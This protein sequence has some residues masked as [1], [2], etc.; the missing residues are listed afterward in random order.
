MASFRSEPAPARRRPG[1]VLMS[2]SRECRADDTAAR[3]V[4][5]PSG[6]EPPDSSFPFSTCQIHPPER[7]SRPRRI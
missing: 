5:V 2:R 4:A 7:V 3:A 1:R 6:K